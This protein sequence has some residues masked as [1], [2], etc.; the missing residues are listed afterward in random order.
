M[1]V[2]RQLSTSDHSRDNAGLRYVYAVASRRSGGVSIGVNLN[3]NNACNW[4]CIY[5]Q[6][7]GLVRGGAPHIDVEWL[8]SELR[9][10]LHEALSG[11]VRQAGKQGESARVVD[12]ALSGNGEPTSAREF[13]EVVSLIGAAIEEFGLGGSVTPRLI[14]NGSLVLR[15]RVGEGLRRLAG[16]GGEVWFKVDAGTAAG[17]GR[18][19]SVSLNSAQ[20]VRWLAHCSS[21]CRTWVQSCMFALDGAGPTAEE[22]D[23]YLEILASAEPHRLAGVHLYGLARNSSQPE[24]PRLTRLADDEM[25]KIAAAIEKIGLTVRVSP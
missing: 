13:P 1:P 17:F 8:A 15:E 19:N 4:R 10:F 7:P 3:P 12:I 14:T 11:G 22:I 6:V 20:V 21:L 2:L 9:Q 25:R 23:R 24:R 5:C 16:I 18:I